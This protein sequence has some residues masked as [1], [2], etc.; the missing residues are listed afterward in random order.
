M[1]KN[2]DFFFVCSAFDS[3]LTLVVWWSGW[4]Y[5]SLSDRC[6]TVGVVVAMHG[7]HCSAVS[8]AAA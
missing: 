7:T 8:Q 3:C 5:C 6:R 4:K 1:G 2:D